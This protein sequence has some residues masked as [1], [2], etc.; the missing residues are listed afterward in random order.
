L[1][2]FNGFRTEDEAESAVEKYIT[3]Q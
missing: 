1:I 2:V 3:A